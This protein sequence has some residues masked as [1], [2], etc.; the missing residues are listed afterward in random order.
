MKELLLKAINDVIPINIYCNVINNNNPQCQL[1]YTAFLVTDI[2]N[3]T[4]TFFGY[5]E[6]ERKK[7]FKEKVITEENISLICR[8]TFL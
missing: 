5:T 3:I 6:D 1:F 4:N 2:D 7:T 8:I